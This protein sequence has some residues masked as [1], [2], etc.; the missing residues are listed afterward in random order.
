MEEE[1][2]R[3]CPVELAPSLDNRIRR[4]LQNPHTILRPFV[5]EG[6]KVLDVGCGPGYFSVEMA[7]LVGDA[8]KV[9]S[10]D[11][12]DGMLKELRKK[13]AGTPLEQRITC[14]Q[15]TRDSINVADKVDFI[16]AFYMA[17]EVPDKEAL[18]RQLKAVLHPEGQL[19][20]VEPKL[21]H[22]SKK[23]WEETTSVAVAN[24]FSVGQGPQMLFS[25]SAVLRHAV[26]NS[27]PA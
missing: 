22:V 2:T 16:L 14:V 4:W 12:Q 26:G 3:V 15:C 25:W 7:N 13:I 19:L 1:R 6:M 18:F 9:I 23:A 11:L 10:A 5:K 8:G 20:L 21:L 24:G 27:T 17:H